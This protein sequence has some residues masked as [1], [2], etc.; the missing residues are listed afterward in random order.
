MGNGRVARL[1][2][3]GSISIDEV[4]LLTWCEGEV[5]SSEG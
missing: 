3:G 2:D 5:L 4:S 1:V